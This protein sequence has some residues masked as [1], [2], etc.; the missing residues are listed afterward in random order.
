MATEDDLAETVALVE[1][2]GRRISS[3]MIASKPVRLLSLA[4]VALVVIVGVR[5]IVGGFAFGGDLFDTTG[6]PPHSEIG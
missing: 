6:G 2:T 4:I 3:A 1:K 5:G